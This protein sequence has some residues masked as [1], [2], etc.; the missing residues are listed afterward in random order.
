MG[1]DDGPGSAATKSEPKKADTQP[2][3]NESK[4]SKWKYIFT[5]ID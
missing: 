4:I 2:I 1:L 3:L 5:D